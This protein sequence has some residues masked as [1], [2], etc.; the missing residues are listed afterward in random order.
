MSLTVIKAG[1]LDTIQ[2]TGRYGFQEGGI[3]PGGAM[4]RFSARLA[5]C[6]LGKKMDAPVLEV[7]YPAMKLQFNEATIV[8]IAGADFCPAVD[9][10][11]IPLYRPAVVNKNTILEFKK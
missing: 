4:D 1:I 10:Y 2:D 6:I 5:N 9:H 8:S 11:P 3:N 7:H